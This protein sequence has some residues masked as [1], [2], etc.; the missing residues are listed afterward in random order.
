MSLNTI[1]IITD[2]FD[3]SFIRLSSKIETA[4]SRNDQ[5]SW[6][7]YKQW[8]QKLVRENKSKLKK[9]KKEIK[10]E[11]ELKSIL[12]NFESSLINIF[13][14]NSETAQKAKDLEYS[15]T[16]FEKFKQELDDKIKGAYDVFTKRTFSMDSKL[17]FVLMPFDKKFKQVYSQGIRPAIRDA[18]L[19]S[20]RADGIFVSQ[21]II[22][23]IW[24]NIN[25]ASII[26]ADLTNRNPNVFYE[27]GLAHAIPKRLVI[28]TQNKDDVP[29]D[30]QHIR[31]IQYDDTKQGR[32]KLRK[33]LT[34]SIKAS[35]S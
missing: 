35:L 2:D 29:F 14:I 25:N 26:V 21:P 16:I 7:N 32:I 30:L 11:K 31:W 6:M 33:S 12:D 13:N 17:C 18:K 9:I 4:N 19:N 22:Q 34:Q 5:L 1:R 20:K 8:Y 3:D 27:V 23:D 10:N 28:L 15:K 24:E